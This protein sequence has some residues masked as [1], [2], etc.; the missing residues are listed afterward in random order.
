MS[1]MLYTPPVLTAAQIRAARAIVEL[2]QEDL[3]EASGVSAAAIK[4]IEA[5]ADAK[6]STLQK[7]QK[8]LEQMGVMFLEEGAVSPG[9]G[10]GLRL[11]R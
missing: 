3:A 5:G 6:A 9:G 10:P 2:R 11:R 7:L 8:A 4:K 1:K